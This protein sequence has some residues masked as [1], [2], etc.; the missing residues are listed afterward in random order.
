MPRSTPTA[1]KP[2][3]C[4][5]RTPPSPITS[6][7]RRSS[8][9]AGRCAATWIFPTPMPPPIFRPTRPTSTT[10]CIPPSPAAP[11]CNNGGST[12]VTG[13]GSHGYEFAWNN[14]GTSG[15][16][17]VSYLAPFANIL[18]NPADTTF[19]SNWAWANLTSQHQFA[20]KINAQ[21]DP[22]FIQGIDSTISGGID[23]AGRDI[24][25]FFGRYLIN[26]TE[27]DGS[28]AGNVNGPPNS[29]NP[30]AGFGP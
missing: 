2:R 15:L 30:G 28:I 6:S 5:S 8:T 26:G 10:A 29:N 18:S 4:I 19:K 3:P 12:C 16:P 24:S 1:P 17:S 22:A 21:Y 20:I 7:G 9:M 13:P 14:G 25:Q 23:Y 27:A 11:G